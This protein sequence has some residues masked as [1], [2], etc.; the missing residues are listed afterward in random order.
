ML[1]RENG[2]SSNKRAPYLGCE[3]FVKKS[4]VQNGPTSHQLEFLLLISK[5][6]EANRLTISLQIIRKPL[7]VIELD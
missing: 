5:R 3:L 7:V 2:T 1:E 6:I 4:N